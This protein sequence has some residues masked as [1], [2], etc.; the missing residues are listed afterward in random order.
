MSQNVSSIWKVKVLGSR[1]MTWKLDTIFF[2]LGTKCD[3]HEL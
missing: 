3:V 1:D 2:N